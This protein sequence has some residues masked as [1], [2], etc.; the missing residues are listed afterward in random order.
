MKIPAQI[1][2][3]DAL[4]NR[5][6][7]LLVIVLLATASTISATVILAGGEDEA[8]QD[9]FTTYE[10]KLAAM[11]EQG[12]LTQEQ[13]DE[14]LEASQSKL[15]DA[16]AWKKE[17]ASNEDAVQ[18]KLTAYEA[19]LAAMVEK[20]ALTQEQVDKKLRSIRAKKAAKAESS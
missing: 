8:V 7:A 15:Y 1:S 6:V 13:A 10:E 12:K 5:W 20:G 9:K 14:K 17:A 16:A 3:E 19:K 18:D 4:K 11:V 2:K